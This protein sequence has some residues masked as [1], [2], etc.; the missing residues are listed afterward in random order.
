VEKELLVVAFEKPVNPVLFH[1]LSGYLYRE[2]RTIYFV[3]ASPYV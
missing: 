1:A 3:G 2:F